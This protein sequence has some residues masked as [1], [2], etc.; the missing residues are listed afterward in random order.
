MSMDADLA[1]LSEEDDED[2]GA[3]ES[4]KSEKWAAVAVRRGNQANR[5]ENCADQNEAGSAECGACAT[6]TA[7]DACGHDDDCDSVVVHVC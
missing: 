6:K 1:A 5:Q 3:D 2:E 7:K 4:C